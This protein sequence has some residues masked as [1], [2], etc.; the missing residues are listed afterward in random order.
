M[1]HAN[2]DRIETGVDEVVEMGRTLGER[3]EQGREVGNAVYPNVLS[4]HLPVSADVMGQIRGMG[5]LITGCHLAGPTSGFG[6]QLGVDPQ[7][8]QSP[9]ASE[10]VDHGHEGRFVGG[11]ITARVRRGAGY[12]QGWKCQHDGQKMSDAHRGVNP[13]PCEL[14]GCAVHILSFLRPLQFGVEP[15]L[16]AAPAP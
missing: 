3:L 13:C 7:G 1:N 2:A 10:L 15:S 16:L 14:G 9:G 5:Q 4:Q 12:Q 8:L 11:R 6:R